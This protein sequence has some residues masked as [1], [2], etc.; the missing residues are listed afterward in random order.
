[1]LELLDSENKERIVKDAFREIGTC[2]RA[3]NIRSIDTTD[4]FVFN[5]AL[6]LID[7]RFMEV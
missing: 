2:S 7:N 6:F 4:G 1:L 5:L 3:I